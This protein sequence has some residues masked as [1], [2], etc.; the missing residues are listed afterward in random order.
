VTSVLTQLSAYFGT[1]LTI[2]YLG[3]LITGTNTTALDLAKSINPNVICND[4]LFGAYDV[5]A[6]AYPVVGQVPVSAIGSA[7]G[8][9]LSATG[10][11][12]IGEL[13][14]ATCAYNGQSVSESE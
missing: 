8:L 1:N 11:A 14:D 13:F 7:V 6:V 10:N 3:S 2:P 5:V 9:D 12:T 4:C